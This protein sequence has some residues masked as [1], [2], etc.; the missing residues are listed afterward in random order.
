MQLRFQRGH[1]I[2]VLGEYN[3][4][5]V[6]AMKI[7][8]EGF[9]AHVLLGASELLRSNKLPF[10]AFEFCDWAEDRAF[11]GRKG[12]AQKILLDAGYK[13]SRLTEHTQEQTALTEPVTQGCHTIIG[14]KL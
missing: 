10:I 7:D 13:L 4:L 9:E 6:G 8:V 2:G 5:D 3:G 12:W 14:R 11:P 1:W